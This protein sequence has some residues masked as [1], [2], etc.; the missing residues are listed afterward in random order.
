MAVAVHRFATLSSIVGVDPSDPAQFRGA[1]R[2]I[3]GVNM[4]PAIT[5]ANTTNPRP[6]LPTT[7]WSLL[8]ED[9]E[10]GTMYKLITLAHRSNWFTP[11][12]S[13]IYDETPCVPSAAYEGRL[14]CHL[15]GEAACD[16][17]VYNQSY[18]T[19]MHTPW[20]GCNGECRY[21]KEGVCI[22]SRGT[23]VVLS[24]GSRNAVRAGRRSGCALRLHRVLA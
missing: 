22:V 18:C 8:V 6:I 14:P 9:Q 10:K 21:V 15:P 7:R 13:A 20:R 1:V 23:P 17:T 16:E 24:T 2:D 4:W 12:G 19:G 5:G 3:D 11:N